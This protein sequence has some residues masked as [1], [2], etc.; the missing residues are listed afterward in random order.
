MNSLTFHLRRLTSINSSAR[1]KRDDWQRVCVCVWPCALLRASSSSTAAGSATSRETSNFWWTTWKLCGPQSSRW[2]RV[3]S[4]ACSTGSVHSE[5]RKYTWDNGVLIF[6]PSIPTLTRCSVKPTLLWR[7]GCWIS[8]S[9]GR[10]R[11][12]KPVWSDRTAYGT[13]SSLKKFRLVSLQVITSKDS[14]QWANI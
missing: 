6:S 13:N 12:L 5:R 4:T 1:P 11:S 8:P 7:N 9:V 10:R 3:C 2:C 14:D